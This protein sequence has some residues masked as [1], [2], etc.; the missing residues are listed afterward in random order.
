MSISIIW[1]SV[2]LILVILQLVF[3]VLILLINGLCRNPSLGFATKARACK[4]A[5]QEGGPKNTSY[6]PE[7]TGKCER[8]NPYTP[9]VTPI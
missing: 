2:L 3:L 7:S 9:K 4:S 5:G 8:M 1:K 6:I